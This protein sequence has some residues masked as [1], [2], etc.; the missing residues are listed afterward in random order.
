M[1]KNIDNKTL[2]WQ[3][4]QTLSLLTKSLQADHCSIT[5]TDTVLGLLAPFTQNGFETLNTIKDGRQNKP[6]I[7]LIS[8]PQ[9]L[10]LFVETALLN[11]KISNL[12]ERCW[13]GPVTFIFQAKSDWPAH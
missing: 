12:I 1:A 3:D 2:W 9:K 11:E 6:Y 8:S 5:S 7:I 13:P 10:E 4:E